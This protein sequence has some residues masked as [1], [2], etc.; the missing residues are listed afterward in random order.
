MATVIVTLRD[1]LMVG[2]ELHHEAELREATLGDVLA[3]TV[4]SERLVLRPDNTGWELA[5]SKT[6][7]GVHLLRRQLMRVGAF[8][9]PFTLLILERISSTDMALL[10]AAADTLD[11]AG[12]AEVARAGEYGSPRAEK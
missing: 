10:Q 9:G 7:M 12:A 3:A 4:E 5:A 6:L 8:Q 2:K 11:R 1:G